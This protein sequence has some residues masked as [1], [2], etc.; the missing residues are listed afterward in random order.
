MESRPGQRDGWDQESAPR[1]AA[2]NGGHLSKR[3]GSVL[4]MPTP[5]ELAETLRLL[6]ASYANANQGSTA[7]AL[8]LA[9]VGTLEEMLPQLKHVPSVLAGYA[10]RFKDG[11][12]FLI[13]VHLIPATAPQSP[14]SNPAP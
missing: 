2:P 14:L 8:G 4:G 11:S 10:I 5:T 12:I 9:E 7:H 6:T 3:F 13:N 1:T